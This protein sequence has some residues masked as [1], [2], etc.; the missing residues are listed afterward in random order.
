MNSLLITGG[1]GFVGK[2]LANF[3][4][5]RCPVVTTYFQ[6]AAASNAESLQLDVT[7][8]D[9]VWSVFD[10]VGPTTVIHAAGNKN[11]R[12][13]EEH[14]EEAHRIN[15]VGTQNVARACRRFN[16]QMIYVSTDLVFES[17]R[18]D[19]R[20]DEIP[21]PTLAYGRSKLQGEVLAREELNEVAIC[22]SG[23]IYGKGSPLLGWFLGEIRAGRTV[24]CLVDVFNTPTYADNLAEMIESVISKRLAGVLHTVGRERVSRFEFFQA[25]ANSL[26][27]GEDLLS[28]VSIIDMKDVLL[29]QPDS[30]LSSKHSV[31]QL[32]VNSNSIREGFARLEANGGV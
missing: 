4:T 23:G 10:R 19:Y 7:D 17:V 30:S 14:P 15:A 2:N 32:E 31:H 8:A 13:C 24:E 1:S 28:P 20:E 25:Y 29:L 6:H 5:S 9:A 22:R 27:L 26:G 3:F 12:F 21:E 11:V 16:T 18:G